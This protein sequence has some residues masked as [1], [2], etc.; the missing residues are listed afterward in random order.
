MT[1]TPTERSLLP[2]SAARVVLDRFAAVQMLDVQFPTTDGR[3][4][5]LNHYT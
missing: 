4:L 5:I 1:Q 2:R 3:K